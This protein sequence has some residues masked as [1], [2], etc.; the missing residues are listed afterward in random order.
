[1]DYYG[2]K[3]VSEKTLKFYD[4]QKL[5]SIVFEDGKTRRTLQYAVDFLN[6]KKDEVFHRAYAD[7]YYTSKVL[8][9]IENAD[10]FDHYSFDTYRLPKN[11]DEEIRVT[12]SNYSKYISREFADKFAAMGDRDVVSTRCYICGAKTRKKVP[13]FTNNGKHYYAIV[14]CHEHGVIKCKIRMRK[15]INNKIFVDKTMK[16]VDNQAV[17]ELMERRNMVRENRKEKRHNK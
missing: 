3:P 1:M 8:Q 15:S 11:K 16:Q 17:K 5:F 12:F 6:I 4:V 2:M 13:W 7:A 10:A 9:R 14:Y